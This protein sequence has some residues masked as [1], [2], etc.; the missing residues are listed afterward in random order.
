MWKR[1]LT[2]LMGLKWKPRKPVSNLDYLGK[3]DDYW[4]KKNS[5]DKRGY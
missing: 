1:L 5:Y 3:L 4:L 2:F